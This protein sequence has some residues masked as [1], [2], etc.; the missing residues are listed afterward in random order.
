MQSGTALNP[1]ATG[2]STPAQLA[3]AAGINTESEREV[4]AHL[5]N[6]PVLELLEAQEKRPD[7]SV[8]C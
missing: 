5:Q 8:F 1:W 2:Y 4:F 7:V 3:A 6:L